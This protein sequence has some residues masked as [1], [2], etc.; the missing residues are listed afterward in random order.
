MRRGPADG[1]PVAEATACMDEGFRTLEIWGADREAVRDALE[2]PGSKARNERGALSVPKFRQIG[3][4]V[5]G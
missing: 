1:S 2:A 5:Y 4:R 3:H